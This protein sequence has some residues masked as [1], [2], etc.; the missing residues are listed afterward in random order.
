M[1][2]IGGSRYID[3]SMLTNVD[4]Y[5]GEDLYL[6]IQGGQGNIE[7]YL[8]LSSGRMAEK[9]LLDSIIDS[10]KIAI[11][12][13][14]TCETVLK[15][16]YQK[17]YT[18]YFYHI[19]SDFTIDSIDLENKIEKYTPSIVLYHSIYGFSIGKGIESIVQKYSDTG[20][21]F[22][23]DRTMDWFLPRNNNYRVDYI[24]GSLRK[25]FAIPDGGFIYSSDIIFE[26]KPVIYN[27]NL[28]LKKINAYYDMSRYRIFNEGSFQEC[29]H[30]CSIAESYIEDEGYYC[31]SPI[32][33][34]IACSMNL[35][36]IRKKRRDNYSYLYK[37]LSGLTEL[38]IISPAI[39]EEI[40]PFHFVV[41]SKRKSEL[42]MHLNKC[43][44]YP[45]STWGTL[46]YFPEI[47]VNEFE[48]FLYESAF[49][50]EIDQM[51]SLQDM[52]RVVNKIYDFYN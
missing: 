8:F 47:E 42:L 27:K 14:F 52:K 45:S 1:K 9:F 24:I 17:K 12:P 21:R 43:D 3:E 25:W 32:S 34:A 6:R 11:V 39:D 33:I 30:N 29:N 13:A 49:F 10:K 20:I 50:L 48:Q 36:M 26:N 51:Y 44:I 18:I 7:D 22:I 16:I 31:M 15:P 38:A 35:K 5:S 41:A 4:K 46:E 37:H 23:E 19:N 2:E 28:I 40:V